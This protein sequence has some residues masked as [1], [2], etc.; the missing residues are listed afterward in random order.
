M[1]FEMAPIRYDIEIL[2]FNSVYCFDF[3]KYYYHTPESHDFWELVYVDSGAITAITDGVACSLTEGQAIFHSPNDSHAHV[4][5]TVD[6][7]RM[8]IISFTSKSPAM[9]F[10]DKKIFDVPESLRR[11]FPLF[12]GEC[13]KAV[14]YIPGIH[15]DADVLSF[16]AAACGSVQLMQ[17]YLLELLFSLMRIRDYSVISPRMSTAVLALTTQSYIELAKKYMDEQLFRPLTLD[18]I[19]VALGIGKSQLCRIFKEQT[20]TSVMAYFSQLKTAEAK[21]LL[22]SGRYTV[23]EISEKLGYGGIHQFSRAFRNLTG[24][25][26]SGYVG[27][28]TRV[29][30]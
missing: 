28:A 22:L 24:L 15:I 8:I 29:P 20:G 16:E 1:S 10:F 25:S 2:G 17:C 9:T 23:T 6:P 21:R 14:G 26:P 18:E 4:S 7:N 13:E 30:E 11:L 3:D 19:C 5:N 12:L 27:A